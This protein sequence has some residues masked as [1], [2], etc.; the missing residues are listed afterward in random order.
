MLI[1][2]K[3]AKASRQGIDEKEKEG[4]DGITDRYL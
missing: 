2:P 4:Y 1:G 3:E